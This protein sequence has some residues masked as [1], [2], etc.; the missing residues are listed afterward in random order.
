MAIFKS[1]NPTLQEKAF[2]GTIFQG[3]STGEE[4]TIQGTMKKFCVLFLLML[5][6]TL[7]AWNQ[8]YKGSNP[9]PLMITGVAGGFIIGLVMSFKKQWSPFLAP[10]FAILEGLFVGSVSA[11]YDYSFKESYP[12]L[13]MQAVGL[14]LIVTLVMYVLYYTRVIKVTNKFRSIITIATVSIM[15]FYLLK[16]VAFLVF[17]T[18]IGAFT[19]A[20]T[21]LG[22]GFSVVVVCLAALNLLLDFDMIEKGAE[23]KAP[24]YMEWYSAFGLLFT[25]VWLYLEILRLLSKLKD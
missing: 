11:A 24:R 6:T 8:Y 25:L 7:L 14:T 16:W 9:M 3:I 13:V 5:A 23:M 10:A 12:G 4:M 21:P 18:T 20:S 17:G 22:I 1:G 19:N 2:E 15:L